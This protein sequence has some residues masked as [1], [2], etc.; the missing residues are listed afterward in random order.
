[1]KSYLKFYGVLLLGALLSACNNEGRRSAMETTTPVSVQKVAKRSIEK[2]ITTTGTAKAVKSIELKSEMV[3]TYHLLRNPKTGRPYQLGDQVDA[4]TVIVRLENREYENNTQ[5]ESKELQV[6]IAEKELEGQEML[7]Q[8][9]GATQKDVNNAKNSYINSKLTLENAHIALNKMD[10]KAPFKGVIVALPY[11][12]PGMEVASGSSLVS[13]MDYS[14]MYI[15][16]QFPENVLNDLKHG[17]SVYVT[18]YN[19]KQDTLSG[20][21]DQLSPAISEET[22]TFTG[23]ISVENPHLLLRPGMF[24]KAEIVTERRDSVLA[25]PKEVI[26]NDK[27][28]QIVFV[29]Q[30]NN[31]EERVVQTGIS[32]ENYIE[33]TGLKA[34]DEIVIK[35][36]EW[37]RNR[38]KIKVM[39]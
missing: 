28:R 16:A 18:N 19:L 24:A 39:K 13:M 6:S 34:G 26:R 3:G 31:A 33:V 14:S 1:M 35:G 21:I 20:Y 2:K 27:G 5:L 22:R 4:G 32:D 29:V 25:I 17:Q 11:F 23:V 9:G 8:K 12:T 15:N 7:Y 10:I 36:Y 38:S 37:L 30:R